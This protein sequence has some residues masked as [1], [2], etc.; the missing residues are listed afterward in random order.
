MINKDHFQQI[1]NSFQWSPAKLSKRPELKTEKTDSTYFQPIVLNDRQ[2]KPIEE[3][4][5]EKAT[6][7]ETK[8]IT[9]L[10]S[11]YSGL[12]SFYESIDSNEIKTDEAKLALLSQMGLE[13]GWG[14]KNEGSKYYNY[15][16]ITTGSSWKGDYF[17]GK[18]KDAKGRPIKQNFRKYANPKEFYKDYMSL[19]KTLYPKAY[20]QLKSDEFDLGEFSRGLRKG[21]VGSYAEAPDY[22]KQLESVYTSVINKMMK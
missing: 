22:E 14:R 17:R 18:D 19:I 20:D 4:M 11:E 15:G 5:Y 3:L 8:E 1:L 16:N 9:D 10:P 21:R 2:E 12:K 7:N 13:S 6:P